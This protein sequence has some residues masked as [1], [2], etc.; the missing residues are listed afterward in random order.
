[1]H[2]NDR[3]ARTPNLRAHLAAVLAAL[4]AL[5][6]AG[7]ITLLSAGSASA[8]SDTNHEDTWETQTGEICQ[9]FD[10]SAESGGFTI[11]DAP[12]AGYVYSKIII[13]KGS[14]TSQG[15]ENTVVDDPL[16]GQTYFHASG[17]G[18]SHVILCQVPG[19][20]DEETPSE[21]VDVCPNIE[22]DQASVPDGYELV[23]GECVQP[24]V[25]TDPVDVCTNID[26]V[27]TS[28]PAGFEEKDGLCTEPEIK[29]TEATDPKPTKHQHPTLQP[30]VLG[31][32]AAVPTAVDA[33]L[34]T[35]PSE[36]DGSGPLLAQGLLGGGAA[37]L[38][39]SGALAL[40]RRNRG[41]H[42]A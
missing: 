42:E 15:E 20:G 22:D 39:V 10:Q 16:T 34:A 25:V 32:E 36:Q 7:G 18:Y 13:K 12:M 14:G 3:R 19:G 28:V 37:L 41:V 9:K 6:L 2:S 35:G 21:P 29:G 23:E 1:M 24:D 33:G 11:E 38:L 31:T 5:M 27:Q 30:T 8:D 4:A 40:G 17:S 26:D